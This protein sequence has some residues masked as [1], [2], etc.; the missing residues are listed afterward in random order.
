MINKNSS[1]TEV[2]GINKDQTDRNNQNVINDQIEID[3]E[4]IYGDVVWRVYFRNEDTSWAEE[5]LNKD[6]LMLRSLTAEE[7][8]EIMSLHNEL[9]NNC[10]SRLNKLERYSEFEQLRS[11]IN[12]FTLELSNLSKT[13]QSSGFSIWVT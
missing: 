13:T 11:F 7:I 2:E 6:K 10:F 8:E 3:R 12:V 9:K 4:A 5:I 1:N